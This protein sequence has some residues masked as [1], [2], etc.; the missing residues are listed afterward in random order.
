MAL[1]A[2][3][4]TATITKDGNPITTVADRGRYLLTFTANNSK[5]YYGEKSISIYVM[6]GLSGNGT[7]ENPYLIGDATDWEKFADNISSGTN[8]YKYYKLAAD[9]T[10]IETMVGT[11]EKMF[12]GTFDGNGKTLSL[13]MTTDGSEYTAPFRYVNGATIVRLHTTGSVDAGNQKDAAG[14]IGCS[15]GTVTITS[16]RSSVAISSRVNGDGTHAGFMGVLNSGEVTFTDCL[17]DGSITGAVTTNCGG[18]VGWRNGT[19]IFNNCLMAG[20]MTLISNEGSAT[21]SRNHATKTI[22]CYYRNDYG[23]DQGTAV[24]SMTNAELATALGYRW[25]VS[26]S[27]VLPIIDPYNLAWATVSG[28]ESNFMT[29]AMPLQS[30]IL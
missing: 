14:L 21:F 19:L 6:T 15:N 5:G 8:A 29:T 28:L 11:S 12:C 9:I 13:S 26:G 25:E 3:C 24:G 18:F 23:D 10:D 22:T 1:D 20:T 30:A 2:D 16:C 7:K 27:D 4:Y 17:F